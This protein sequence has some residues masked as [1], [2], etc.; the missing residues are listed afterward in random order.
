[1]NLKYHVVLFY[2]EKPPVC[3]SSEDLDELLERALGDK[4]IAG[5]FFF[6]GI[7]HERIQDL[8]IDGSTNLYELAKIL[9]ERLSEKAT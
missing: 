3:I 1:M 6:Y 5:Y 2:K 9:E 7:R 8:F 4:E